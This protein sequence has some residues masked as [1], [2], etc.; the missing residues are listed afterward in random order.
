[1]DALDHAICDARADVLQGR[2][3]TSAIS[4]QR[5]SRHHCLKPTGTTLATA[6]GWNTIITHLTAGMLYGRE[7]VRPV[8]GPAR[9]HRER[10]V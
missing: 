9:R 7:V 8:D 10:A 2:I 5:F 4:N 6:R 3:V 1:M